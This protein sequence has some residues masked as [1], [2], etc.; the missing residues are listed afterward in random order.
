[1]GIVY[2]AVVT[3][4]DTGDRQTQRL[5]RRAPGVEAFYGEDLVE[6]KTPDGRAFQVRAVAGDLQAFPIRITEGRLFRPNT[7]EAIAGQGLLDWLG[8]A[9]GDTLT[10]IPD[11]SQGR[12]ITWH[13]VGRYPEPANAGQ[14]LMASLPTLARVVRS[15]DPGAYYLRLDPQADT[16]RL[17]HFLEPRPDS[18]LNFTLVG[19]AIPGVVVYLQLAIFMLAAILIGIAL[20]N[21]FNTSWLAMQEK[22]R[23]IGVLKTVG[24][25]PGQVVAMVSTAA[26]FLGVLAACIGLPA[27]LV[28]TKA[29]LATVSNHYGFGDVEVSVNAFLSLLVIPAMAGVSIA[30]SLIPGR[31]AARLSIVRVLRN[32]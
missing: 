4:G 10:V 30:G 8:L 17:K 27:G 16:A 15:A 26:G 25:T 12:S 20:I 6:V 5:L 28:L 11:E 32:E 22:V 31:R 21:V 1:L 3:R 7:D 14:M 19:Q 9:V 23:V 13:I 24:M 18:D 29:L 2:D